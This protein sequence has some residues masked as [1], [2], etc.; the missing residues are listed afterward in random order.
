MT[1]ILKLCLNI[2]SGMVKAGFAG[3]DA[4][5]LTFP[6]IAGRP[7][8]QGV[9]VGMGQRDS[10]IGDEAMSKR[11]VLWLN[12]PVQNGIIQNW[13]N[14]EKILH[15]IFYD[16]F[17]VALEEH[18]VFMT[19]FVGNPK[20]QSE[21][22]AQVIFETFNA[23]S[24]YLND[25]CQ[26][27]LTAVDANKTALVV[28]IGTGVSIVEPFINGNP[29]VENVQRQ[30][31]AG[32]ELNLYMRKLLY[33]ENH[34]LPLLNDTSEFEIVRD[35]KEKVCYVALDYQKELEKSYQMDI[36]KLFELPHGEILRVNESL[37]KCPEL[38]FQPKLQDWNYRSIQHLIFDSISKF[39]IQEQKDLLQNVILSGG[40][41]MFNGFAERLKAEL[42]LITQSNVNVVSLEYRKYLGW[43]GSSKIADKFTDFYSIDEYNENGKIPSFQ[44]DP[45]ISE[46]R[47]EFYIELEKEIPSQSLMQYGNAVVIDQGSNSIKAGFAGENLPRI[48]LP[49]LIGKT[50]KNEYYIG[51]ETISNQELSLEYITKNGRIKNWDFFEKIYTH[52][53]YK[54]LNIEPSDKPILITEPIFESKAQKEHLTQIFIETFDVPSIAFELQPILTLIGL[55]KKTGVVVDIG[56]ELTQILPIYDGKFSTNYKLPFYQYGGKNITKYLMKIM[57]KSGYYF[58]STI[59]FEIVKKIKE[60]LGYISQDYEQELEISKQSNQ[61]EKSFNFEADKEV[62]LNSARFECAESFF[63]PLRFYIDQPSIQQ[64]I[65]TSIELFEPN[66]QNILLSNIILSGGTTMM[67]GFEDRLRKE[68]I[69]LSGNQNVFISSQMNNDILPWIGGSI[70]SGFPEFSQISLKKEEY[71]EFG[72][73]RIHKFSHNF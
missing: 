38:L 71:E 72:P 69:D 3:D 58:S 63:Q 11:G 50:I 5:R 30:N 10:Y 49:N 65:L 2:G 19:E 1:G 23:Q 60:N 22:I 21:K 27:A 45:Q 67:N 43:V 33:S 47:N 35:I 68:L 70:F 15:Y 14:Y 55:N 24:L 12:H 42:D 6:S 32:Y 9:M 29:I 31:L 13:D 8:Y 66:I 48:K 37:F 56:D 57:K 52:L 20:K 26:S 51:N 25:F 36:S 17:R 18:P 41:T 7:K 4:P 53:F 40:S 64:S 62:I 16:A 34:D 46:M 61:C 73:S 28:H 44:D 39:D 59:D 54:E